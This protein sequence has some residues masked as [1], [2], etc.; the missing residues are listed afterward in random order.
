M[1]DFGFREGYAQLGAYRVAGGLA[2]VYV[3]HDESD[4]PA[5]DSLEGWIVAGGPWS[6]VVMRAAYEPSTVNRFPVRAAVGAT[7]RCSWPSIEAAA[8]I[9][10]GLADAA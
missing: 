7:Q 1:A 5:P 10:A 9:A 4:T 2:W 6:N 8:L 3:R